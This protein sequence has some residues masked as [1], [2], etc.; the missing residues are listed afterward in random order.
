M[1]SNDNFSTIFSHDSK[2]FSF[3][4]GEWTA[5]WWQWIISISKTNNPG[6]DLTGEYCGQGQQGP[7]WF[8]VGTFENFQTAE[9]KCTLPKEKAILIPVINSEKSY[10]EFPELK[11]ENAVRSRAKD[12]IDRVTK[13]I[14]II[15][16]KEIKNL[17]DYRVQSPLFNVVFP[18]D[19]IYGVKAGITQAVSDG[20]W[21]LLRPS[22]EPSMH[23]LE[24]GGE[25]RCLK[26]GLEF[27][28]NVKYHIT[29]V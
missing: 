7:V 16:G 27:A 22:K 26:D 10:A 9:R 8:I 4:L 25:A 28:T 19:N 13:K 14:I 17:Q 21:I 23:V 5:K 1:Y 29:L 6:N 15:D 2:P 3:T 12:A 11:D 18:E 24:F 20:Y